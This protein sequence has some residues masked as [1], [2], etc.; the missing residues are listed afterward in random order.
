MCQCDTLKCRPECCWETQTLPTKTIQMGGILFAS[1]NW[2][3][4]GADLLIGPTRHASAVVLATNYSLF[5]IS[6]G[7][8]S[9]LYHRLVQD[10]HHNL[11]CVLMRSNFL[12]LGKHCIQQCVVR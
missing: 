3:L 12:G 9:G 8:S 11:V 1:P 10:R 5:G 7:K 2:N 6:K 4:A